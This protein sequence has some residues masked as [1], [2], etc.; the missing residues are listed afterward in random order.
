VDVEARNGSTPVV[1]LVH[2]AF[3][4]ASCWRGVVAQLCEAG[5]EAFALANPL[6]GLEPDASYI[7]STVDEIDAPVILV[8]H[9]YGGAVI[10]VAAATPKNVVG[11]V[12]VAGYALEEGESLLDLTTPFA[13]STLASFLRPAVSRAGSGPPAVELHIDRD[14]F[15]WLFSA[16]LPADVSAV[17]A[18]S[19]RPITAA[20]FEAKASAAAWKRLPSW[21]IVATADRVI[22]PDAQRFMAARA[23]AATVEVD[24]SHAVAV[25]QPA[26]VADQI[27]AAALSAKRR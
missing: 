12:Y 15:P 10:T 23:S 18:R 9:S 6:R 19:Q 27:R 25:S 4:D 20:A 3:T 14:A 22:A 16:D 17:A 26:A 21:Y 2:G 1:L 11:L 7:A 5:V 8:G 13:D 24:A